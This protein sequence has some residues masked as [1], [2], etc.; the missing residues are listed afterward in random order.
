MIGCL[1]LFAG[2]IGLAYHSSELVTRPFQ[3]E[4]LWVGVIRLLAIVFGLFILRGH[5]WARWLAL[6]WVAYHVVLSALHTFSEFAIHCLLLAAIAWFLFRPAA[7]RFFLHPA[8]S[9]RL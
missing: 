1:F 7:A 6:G 5:N 2:A 3:Y 8:A 4:R 9:Q